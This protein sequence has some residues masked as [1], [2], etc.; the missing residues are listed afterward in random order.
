MVTMSGAVFGFRCNNK[1]QLGVVDPSALL[2]DI[3]SVPSEVFVA[4]TKFKGAIKLPN[5]SVTTWKN[6]LQR[7]PLP[8]AP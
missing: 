3:V 7:N 2:D 5:G 6:Q 1:H 4:I 8:I